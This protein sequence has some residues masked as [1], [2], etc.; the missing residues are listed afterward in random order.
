M[1]DFFEVLSVGI[2]VTLSTPDIGNFKE[3]NDFFTNENEA[4]HNLHH[5]SY[6]VSSQ[7]NS[8]AS[9]AWDY[10]FSILIFSRSK[11]HGPAVTYTLKTVGSI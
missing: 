10:I 1:S 2:T 4:A 7:I 5:S 6:F 9:W 8:N 11:A 3:P